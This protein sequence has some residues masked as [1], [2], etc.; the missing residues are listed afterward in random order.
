MRS[1][2]DKI[3]EVN[4]RSDP[5]AADDLT[6]VPLRRIP[7]QARSRAKVSRALAAADTIAQRDGVD[8]LTLTHVAEEADLSVGA[9]HQ[10]LPDRDA[11]V[12]ALVARYHDRIEAQM[13]EIIVGVQGRRIDDP[14]AEVIG[15]ISQ[16]YTEERGVRMVRSLSGQPGDVG[17][18]HKE[19]M[20]IKVRELLLACGFAGIDMT[21]VRT[22]FVTADA[23]MHEAFSGAD[24]PDEAL[25][26]ELDVML[27][28]YL[29][30]R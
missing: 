29:G 17:R 18:E 12:A 10:Y 14:V 13:D 25:L 11:I 9:L 28:A 26:T 8:A 16:I 22:V 5:P 19:R 2:L 20:A 23:I 15:R 4:S 24:S 21:V 6:S 27:R 3:Y 30:R 1:I 7:T